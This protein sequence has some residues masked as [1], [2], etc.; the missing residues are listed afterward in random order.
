VTIH[1]SS[2]RRAAGLDSIFNALD[3]G[4]IELRTGPAEATPE[5]PATGTLLVTLALGTPAFASAAGGPG[6]AVIKASNTIATGTPVASGRAGH[7]RSID[8]SSTCVMIG[9]VAAA[10][11]DLNIPPDIVAGVPISIG[12]SALSLPF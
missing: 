7:F 3:G 11:S 6:A 5:S 9:D 10:G 12:P 8:G 2:A 4:L 1:V